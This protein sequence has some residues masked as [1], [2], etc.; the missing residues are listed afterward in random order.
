MPQTLQLTDFGCCAD[1][2]VPCPNVLCT[3]LVMRWASGEAST[4]VAMILCSWPRDPSPS[5]L[6]NCVELQNSTT[7]RNRCTCIMV[8][9]PALAERASYVAYSLM[10]S[11]EAGLLGVAHHLLVKTASSQ[12][13]NAMAQPLI[14]AQPRMDEGNVHRCSG[15]SVSRL[16]ALFWTTDRCSSH[17]C[18]PRS[19]WRYCDAGTTQTKTVCL[20][21]APLPHMVHQTICGCGH[22]S[23]RQCL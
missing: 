18:A 6:T 19:S 11:C 16:S 1:E 8:K 5:A 4:L 3:V 14:P 9:H 10:A 13:M 7:C 2:L 22:S 20:H 21:H 17:T 15:V 23:L 12:S